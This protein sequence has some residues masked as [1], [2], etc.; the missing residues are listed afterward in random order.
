[1]FPFSDKTILLARE[2][3]FTFNAHLNKNTFVISAPKVGSRYMEH[4][5]K[6]QKVVLRI[7]TRFSKKED[8]KIKNFKSNIDDNIF[9]SGLHKYDVELY[10]NAVVEEWNNIIDK[11]SK[12]EFV[13]LYRNPFERFKAA[14]IQDFASAISFNSFNSNF[15]IKELLLKEGFDDEEILLFL[16]DF[17]PILQSKTMSASFNSKI[18]FEMLYLEMEPMLEYLLKVFIKS[19]VLKNT[20]HYSN[21]ISIIH[22]LDT[23]FNIFDNIKYINLDGDN[24]V[25]NYFEKE[26]L[27]GSPTK[28]SN[29]FN[30]KALV[31]KIIKE[32][33]IL[34]DSLMMLLNKDILTYSILSGKLTEKNE[35]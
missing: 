4:L 3:S 25:E 29:N 11:K 14:I 1:M 7:N 6:K 35:S 19:A 10:E 8:L 12:K 20:H 34:K 13:V 15:F 21:Y 18:P 31:E 9:L 16:Q 28:H 17:A 24:E 33:N 26:L 22:S 23:N 30:G 2:E 27:N 5:F 32:N